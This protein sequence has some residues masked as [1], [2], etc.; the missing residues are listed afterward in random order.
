MTALYRRTELNGRAR[1]IEDHRAPVAPEHLRTL[2]LG[3]VRY[4]MGR[5]SA[6]PSMA[7]EMVRCYADQI[8]P[9][10][11]WQIRQEVQDELDRHTE[12][13]EF[14]LLGDD[15]DVTEWQRLVRWIEGRQ[16]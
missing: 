2:L 7:C 3:Y 5:R 15:C 16:K 8:H 10:D 6:A 1:Y 13:P 9:A 12:D 14:G 11:L 4:A